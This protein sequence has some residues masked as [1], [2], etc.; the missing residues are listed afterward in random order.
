MALLVTR[1]FYKRF[2]GR[3]YE[4]ESQASCSILLS[5]LCFEWTDLLPP[6]FHRHRCTYLPMDRKSVA[7]CI[8]AAVH[9]EVSTKYIVYDVRLSVERFFTRRQR[10]LSAAH[11][12]IDSHEINS[13]DYDYH[14]GTKH[15]HKADRGPSRRT[16]SPCLPKR[17][18]V[19]ISSPILFLPVI[20]HAYPL[21]S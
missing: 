6:R 4:G 16:S 9:T 18:A 3:K 8:H 13:N 20:A 1:H 15:N 19:G 7:R 2:Q 14:D 10:C 5:C 12:H 17:A 11:Q 21:T